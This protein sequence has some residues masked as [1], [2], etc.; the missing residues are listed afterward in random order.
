MYVINEIKPLVFL[1]KETKSKYVVD[2]KKRTFKFALDI[3][4]LLKI[5][6]NTKEHDVIKYQLSKSGTSV[7]A[8]YEESQATNS[9]AGFRHK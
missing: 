4:I 3:L 2:L 8:N 5:V 1:V 6:S 7:G 9:K